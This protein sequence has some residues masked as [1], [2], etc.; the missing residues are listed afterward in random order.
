MENN[1]VSI[2]IFFDGTGNNGINACSPQKPKAKNKSYHNNIT[3]VYKLFG[4]FNGDKKI[5]IEGVG[6]VTGAE[7]SNFAMVTCRNPYRFTGY[8]SDDKLAKANAFVN[9][10]IGD[11]TKEYHFYVYGF[12]RGS[13]L[14]R[15][16]C[17]E[18][19]KPNSKITGNCK[20]KFLG[21][22]DTV[23]STPFNDYNVSLL[24]GIERALQICAVNECRYFFPLTG[25]FE[26]SKSKEDTKAEIGNAV[27]KEIFVPGAHADVGGGYLEGPQSVY[28]SHDFVITD[29]VDSY[30]SNVKNTATDAEG[31]KIWEALL[32][33]YHIDSGD[34]FSQAYV[35]RDRVYNDLPKVYGKLMLN[36]TNALHPVFSTDFD[37]S[38]FDIDPKLHSFLL[39]FSDELEK[40]VKDLSL[41][42]KPVYNYERFVDYTHFSSNFGLYE[43][44]LLLRTE[45]EIFVEMLN[46]GLNVPGGAV[47]KHAEAS[48]SKFQKEIHFLEHDVLTDYAYEGN[49]PNNVNWS[50]SI[51]IK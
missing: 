50:R 9:E 34:F 42:L 33:N 29:E 22:F 15:N 43:K 40:Y 28:V 47:V 45:E 3:N 20:V 11:D 12:S 4:L 13:M 41:H 32:E 19:L 16:F 18:L 31:N 5:Y 2:G 6:T 46:D 14:A 23:E 25:F 1:I 35:K 38:N 30:I 26:Y 39:S 37:E 10:I 49:I 21:V 17:Y 24:P 36:E 7:D 48:E 27:W 44:A 8:S 51:L